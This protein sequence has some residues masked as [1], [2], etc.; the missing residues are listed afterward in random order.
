[1]HDPSFR[2]LRCDL[3]HESLERP[4]G[5]RHAQFTF[6]IPVLAPQA[7]RI[8]SAVA[9]DCEAFLPFGR[10]SRE[11]LIRRLKLN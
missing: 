1:M 5:H 9:S 6:A 2:E 11:N 3:L 10:T 8:V 7:D 4:S